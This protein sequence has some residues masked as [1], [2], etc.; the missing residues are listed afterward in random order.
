[1]KI[2][3]LNHVAIHV[4]DVKRSSDFYA[5]VLRLEAIPRPAFSFPGAWFRLGTNQELHLIADY[6]PAFVATTRNNHFALQV[7]TLD[8]WERHLQHVGAVFAPR[9]RRPDGAWQVF[10]RD[11]DDHVIELFTS[12]G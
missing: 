8:D 12:P 10:L 9:K 2:Q 7:D 6:G 4:T 3:Q 5:R 1:M 11:P